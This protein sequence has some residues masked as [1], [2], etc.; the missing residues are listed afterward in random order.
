MEWQPNGN[1]FQNLRFPY[2]VGRS[3][4][5]EKYCQLGRTYHSALQE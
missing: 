1:I 4:P 2:Q 5:G 3:Q